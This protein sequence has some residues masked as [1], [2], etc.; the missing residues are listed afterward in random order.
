MNILNVYHPRWG[1]Y[2]LMRV[3]SVHFT[4]VEKLLIKNTQ[5]TKWSPE[6]LTNAHKYCKSPETKNFSPFEVFRTNNNS[7]INVCGKF[8]M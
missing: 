8:L 5:K 4:Q 6:T 2:Y 1:L 7:L 3:E